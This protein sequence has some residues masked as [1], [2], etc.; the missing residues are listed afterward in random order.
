MTS[1]LWLQPP[2]TPLWPPVV[3][4]RASGTRDQR[5]MAPSREL[6]MKYCNILLSALATVMT[7]TGIVPCGAD[8]VRAASLGRIAEEWMCATRTG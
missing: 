2:L 5:M 7:L 8:A 1:P 4:P 6:V 3:T